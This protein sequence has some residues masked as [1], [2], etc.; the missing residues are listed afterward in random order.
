MRIPVYG[1][2]YNPASCRPSFWLSRKDLERRIARGHI[3]MRDG[4]AFAHIMEPVVIPFRAKPQPH[5]ARAPWL[6]I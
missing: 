3:E 6:I 2:G 5:G 4:I 1:V